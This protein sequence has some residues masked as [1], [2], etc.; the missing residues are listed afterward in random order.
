MLGPDVVVAEAEGL[1][2][3]QLE[4]LL[5]PR[6]EGDLSRGDFFAGTDDPDDL[7]SNP[8][9]RDVERL[10]D[11]RRQ[12]LF[13]TQQAEQDVLGPDVV[14]LER[15]RLFLGQDDHLSCAL[16][17]SLEQVSLPYPSNSP[18]GG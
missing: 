14:V 1:P 16:C 4:D 8:L 11:P 17:E 5:R 13:L 18:G 2:E 15:A 9:D 10:E 7:G 6:G 12:P 3:R